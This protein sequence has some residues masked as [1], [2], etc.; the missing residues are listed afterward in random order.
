MDLEKN[1]QHL[2]FSGRVECFGLV[3]VRQYDIL[4]FVQAGKLPKPFNFI[5]R[6]LDLLLEV[7]HYPNCRHIFHIGRRLYL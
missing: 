3:A 5:R 4:R 1:A 2:I 7:L 6:T